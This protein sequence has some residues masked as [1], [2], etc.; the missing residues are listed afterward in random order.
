MLLLEI[1]QLKAAKVVTYSFRYSSWALPV[2]SRLIARETCRPIHLPTVLVQQ[3]SVYNNLINFFSGKNN[4]FTF[5]VTAIN[6]KKIRS[7]LINLPMI[8]TSK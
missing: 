5:G 3:H 8:F 4:S 6:E 1:L 7:K 2:K